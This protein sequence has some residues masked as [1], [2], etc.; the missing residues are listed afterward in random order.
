[1]SDTQQAFEQALD[2]AAKQ[3]N[4][5]AARS[6]VEDMRRHMQRANP[7]L[8]MPDPIKLGQENM[9]QSIRATAKDEFGVG[10]QRLAG[11]GT[12]PA[13]AGHA[14]A[15]LA[16]ADNQADIQNW[17]AL[18]TAT[19][20]TQ[21]GNV[22]GNALLYGALPARAM[23]PVLSGA[24]KVAPWLKP[25]ADVAGSRFGNVADVALTQG[26]MNAAMTPGGAPERLT[27]GLLG[28]TGAAIPGSVAAVQTGRRAT[29]LQGKQL[30]LAEA[31]RRET[32]D[33]TPALIAQLDA[34]HYPTSGFGVQPSAA[35]LTRNPSLEVMESGSRVRTPDLWMNFDKANAT[36]RW[37]RLEEAAGTPEELTKL[38]TA[39]DALTTPQRDAALGAMGGNFF[40]SGHMLE[41]LDQKL[42]QLA[43]GAN[44]PNKDVQTLVAYVRDE[45]G[46]GV[47]PEQLYSVRKML[48]DGIKAGPTSE[49]SQAARAARPQRMEIIGEIDKALNEMSGGKWQTYLDTYKAASPEIS[50]K[51]AMQNIV[52]ALKSGRPVGEVPASMGERPAPYALGKLVERHGTKEFGSRDI[53]QLLPQHRALVEAL[54]SDLNAQTGTMLPRATL[55]SPTASNL[56]NAGRVHQLTNGAIDAAGN[57]IPLLG[58]TVAASVKGSLGR[59]SEE[60]LA[61]LLKDPVALAEALR[62]AAEA[63]RMLNK[64]GRVGAA[65]GAGARASRE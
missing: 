44:R 7:S 25:A 33:N 26:G 42:T 54:M 55:G 58:G 63:E 35:M 46:Q 47:T 45:L 64:T 1:M 53:D 50:S 34:N 31:L 20:D 12:A 61:T 23:S 62:R 24:S 30:A 32:G 43:S 65:A 9:P 38:R 3:G 56:A 41:P 5:E 15:Q 19:P 51:G 21:I 39:R 48:T 57:A 8:G 14:V 60:A 59:K 17:R 40:P 37:Q 49:L 27:A 11:I 4:V 28:S 13:I 36:A 52:E 18:S 16:G 10:A 29:T 2:L 6:I 22:G